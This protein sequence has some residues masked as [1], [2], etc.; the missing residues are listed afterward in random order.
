MRAISTVNAREHVYSLATLESRLQRDPAAWLHRSLRVRALVEG[1]CTQLVGLY[2]ASCGSWR[3][4]LTDPNGPTDP[5]AGTGDQPLPLSWGKAPALLAFL[6]H[7]PLLKQMVPLP[8]IL[9]SGVPAV[10]QIQLRPTACVLS[11]GPPC[12][13]AQLLDAIPPDDSTDWIRIGA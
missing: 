8:Q 3:L 5:Y 4:A 1:Q 12:Y 9:H 11:A 7:L 10:Y 6:R 13:E 2:V